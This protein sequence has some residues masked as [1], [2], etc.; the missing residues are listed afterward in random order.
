MGWALRRALGAAVPSAPALELVVWPGLVSWHPRNSCSG[1]TLFPVPFLGAWPS[2][3][4]PGFIGQ[5]DSCLVAQLAI[6]VP[7][8]SMASAASSP[9]GEFPAVKDQLQSVLVIGP[10]CQRSCRALEAPELVPEAQTQDMMQE[11]PHTRDKV[12]EGNG[13]AAKGGETALSEALLNFLFLD[14]YN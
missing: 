7:L 12:H 13:S 3:D 8:A 11:Q 6:T 5:S 10:M 2:Q 4:S 14:S 9:L 1:L